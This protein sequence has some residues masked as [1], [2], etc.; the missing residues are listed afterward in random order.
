VRAQLAVGRINNDIGFQ[1]QKC[2]DIVCSADTGFNRQPGDLTGVAALFGF[3]V[4]VQPHEVEPRVGN[5][6]A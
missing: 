2:I 6:V 1:R 4:G 3:A 5:G